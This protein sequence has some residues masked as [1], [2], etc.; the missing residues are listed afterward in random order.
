M[1]APVGLSVVR[2]QEANPCF[3]QAG[4]LNLQHENS[5]DLAIRRLNVLVCLSFHMLQRLALRDLAN[6]G[7]CSGSLAK[8]NIGFLEKLVVVPDG[9]CTIVPDGSYEATDFGIIGGEK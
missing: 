8:A 2:D 3:L 6:K 7:R 4:V 9:Y 1:L 5:L